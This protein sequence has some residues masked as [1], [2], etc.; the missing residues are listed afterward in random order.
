MNE[1][2]LTPAYLTPPINKVGKFA[3]TISNIINPVFVGIFVISLLA[4]RAIDS[5]IQAVKWLSLAISLTAIPTM[6][7]VIY[8]VKT[9]YLVDIYMPDRKRRLKPMSMI[10]V[11]L[12]I[13]VL[14]LIALGAPIPIILLIN[15]VLV[16]VMLLL[17]VTLIWKISFHSATITTAATVTL[18][19]GSELTWLL[20]PMIP[21]VGWSR[22]HLHRHTLMQVIVG[23]VAGFGVA[24]V[25]FPIITRYITF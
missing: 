25:A 8:L 21:L 12:I 4:F 17:I 15:A 13:S 23:C 9:G 10:F 14:I 5:P 11:W 24:V 16:Q 1:M 19:M 6:S 20:L 3:S 18:L 22:V 7:Y 2:E